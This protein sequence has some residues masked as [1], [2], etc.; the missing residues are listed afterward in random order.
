MFTPHFLMEVE[1]GDGKDID[2][3]AIHASEHVYTEYQRHRLSDFAW[4][5]ELINLP[6]LGFLNLLDEINSDSKYYPVGKSVTGS[7][8]TAA[9]IW[10]P[11]ISKWLRKQRTSLSLLASFACKQSPPTIFRRKAKLPPTDL[12]LCGILIH[13]LSHSP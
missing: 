7:V 1:L 3:V 11:N 9:K 5:L 13:I 10:S 4:N 2:R 6:K 12:C 8:K